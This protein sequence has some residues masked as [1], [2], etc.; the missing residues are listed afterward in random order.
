MNTLIGLFTRNTHPVPPLPV[1][2][3]QYHSD[4]LP[5]YLLEKIFIEYLDPLTVIDT[6]RLVSRSWRQ[7]A[8]SEVVVRELLQSYGFMR[9]NGRMTED[10][11]AQFKKCVG[12]FLEP[13]P[14]NPND[15]HTLWHHL[16]QAV[17]SNPRLVSERHW[18]LVTESF[19]FYSH[20][21]FSLSSIQND[22]DSPAK[23]EW[24]RELVLQLPNYPLKK[25][26]L[27]ISAN[28]EIDN[29]FN[30]LSLFL[31]LFL[32]F[33]HDKEAMVALVNA[34]DKMGI[35]F[36]RYENDVRI[37]YKNSGQWVTLQKIF[38]VFKE[39][40]EATVTL[41][42]QKLEQQQAKNLLKQKWAH[43]N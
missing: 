5:K 22:D 3:E 18:N 42:Y 2:N 10:F 25:K 43:L 31:P 28:I 35:V 21:L 11:V 40:K 7:I 24:C 17:K 8:C 39:K 32:Y 34:F 6:A 38:G 27:E 15:D 37:N 29:F 23:F 13:W 19:P 4:Q 20:L 33:Q 1:L 14:F 41:I 16:I 9:A 26:D 30:S 12:W 36:N